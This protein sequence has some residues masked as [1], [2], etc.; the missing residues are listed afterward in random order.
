MM[1]MG[2]G[3][4]KSWTLEALKNTN[5][6]PDR[7]TDWLFSH[8]E[9]VS[10]SQQKSEI[11]LNEEKDAPGRYTLFAFITHMG[12]TPLSG[13]YVSHIKHDDKWV[14]FND[15]KVC[16]SQEPPSKMAYIYF[17]RRV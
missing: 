2:L 14:I 3:F 16:E 8:E 13:H 17:Y 5:G 6:D 15:S 4:S 1:G 12:T 7:A 10:T 11:P 9:P